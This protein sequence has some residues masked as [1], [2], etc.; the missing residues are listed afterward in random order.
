M[1]DFGV[2]QAKLDDL[3]RRMVVLNLH[4]SDFE[5]DFVRSG[6]PGGQKINKTSVAVSLFHPSSGIRIK[7]AE[8][9]SQALNRF[10]ARRLL[11]ERLEAIVLGKKAKIV[12]EREKIRRQ[13]RKRSKRAKE[14]M[15][16]G[17]KHQSA[18]KN[19]RSKSFTSDY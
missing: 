11:V 18:K 5:E 14:K 16:A 19:N 10:L 7:C 6:G 1:T 13:K 4:E 3:K 2:S 12:A 9:R 15:L 17:K 8:S